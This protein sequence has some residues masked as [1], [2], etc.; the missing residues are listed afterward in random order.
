[1]ITTLSA[2]SL[3]L[4]SPIKAQNTLA[5]MM[6]I[7]VFMDWLLTRFVLEEFYIS[8]REINQE[9]S[10][11]LTTNNDKSK[12]AWPTCLTLLAIVALI[13]PPGVEVFDINQFLSEDDP[14]LDEFEQL[15]NQYLIA[16]STVTW[17]IVDVEGLSLIHI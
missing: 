4:F 5:L 12:W 14:A 1:M 17:I 6:I 2:V 15:Q 11:K 7:G 3:S 13:S 10:T 9:L 8:R 16:S